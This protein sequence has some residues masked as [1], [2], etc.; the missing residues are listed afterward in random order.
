M[1]AG[2]ANFVGSVRMNAPANIG[3]TVVPIELNAW[4]SVSRTGALASGPRIAAYGFTDVCSA[5]TPAP[6]TK[7][8]VRK[9]GKFTSLAAGIKSRQPTT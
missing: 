2:V 6:T 5:V 9:S 8:A 3:A 1:A 4:A 7:Q